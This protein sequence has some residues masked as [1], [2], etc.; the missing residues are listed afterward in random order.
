[1]NDPFKYSANTNGATRGN[2]TMPNRPSSFEQ[3]NQE[4]SK[5]LT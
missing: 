4:I 2:I 3:F 5:K 1:M